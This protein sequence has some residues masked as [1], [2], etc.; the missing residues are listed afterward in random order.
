M[1]FEQVN[2]RCRQ[3]A[4][5]ERAEANNRH[6]RATAQ[7]LEDFGHFLFFDF[8]FIDEHHGDVVANWI[9]ALARQAFET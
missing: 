4:V 1:H 7:A 9:D 2:R 6:P 3:N 8:G 5:P